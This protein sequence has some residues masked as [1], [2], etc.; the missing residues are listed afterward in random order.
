MKVVVATENFN[1]V[2][3]GDS[4]ILKLAEE[5]KQTRKNLYNLTCYQIS[6]CHHEINLVEIYHGSASR[7]ELMLYPDQIMLMSFH[8]WD[9][10]LEG[11][12]ARRELIN[13]DSTTEFFN[14]SAMRREQAIKFARSFTEKAF[15]MNQ[16]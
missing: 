15:Q 4:T 7:L 11:L 12:K 9:H 13:R 3:I 6:L 1:F 2:K 14:Q 8:Y 10:V 16:R 5:Y